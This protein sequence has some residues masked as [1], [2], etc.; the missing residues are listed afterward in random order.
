MSVSSPKR[1]TTAAMAMAVMLFAGACSA[2]EE[3]VTDAVASLE[4]TEEA[5]DTATTIAEESDGVEAPENPEDAFALFEGCMADAGIELRLPGGG[6][7]IAVDG[8]D[9]PDAGNPGGVPG[10]FDAADFAKVAEKCEEHL[11]NI[12][13]GFD[14]SPEEQAQLDDARLEWEECMRN[15]GVDIPEGGFGS[16]GGIIIGGPADGDGADPQAGGD[17]GFDDFTDAAKICEQIFQE[18]GVGIRGPGSG[19]DQ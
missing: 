15:E 17:D 10:D 1:R 19:P 11:A 5:A 13:S 6:G 12:D 9:G 3:A 16:G 8:D 14:L 18:I 2:S 7:G 4:D